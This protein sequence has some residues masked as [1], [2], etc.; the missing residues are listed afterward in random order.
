MSR[1][2]DVPFVSFRVLEDELRGELEACFT[3][4]LNNSWYIQ[5]AECDAFEKAFA[6]YVGVR[7]CVGCGNGLDALVLA[8]R[9]LGIGPGDEVIVPSNTFIATVLAVSQ[10]GAT[11]VLVEPNLSTYNLDASKVGAAITP[12]TAAIMPVHL[13]G[14]ACN[15]DPIIELAREHGLA[16]VEDCAQAH[17]ATYKGQGVGTFGV[18][19]GFS[20]Y[21]GKNLGAMGDAGAVVTND[22]DFARKVVAIGNYGSD[23]KY[24]HIY[25]GV[26]SRLDELQAAILH[27]KLATLERTN[28]FRRTVASRYLEG[29][30]NPLVVLPV[31]E[32]WA[33]PVW[34]IFAVRCEQRDELQ[35]HL[36]ERGIHTNIHYPTPIHLQGA[37]EDLP[38]GEGDLPI[39]EQISRTQLSIPMYYGMSDEQVA[40]VVESIN[41]F[42]GSAHSKQG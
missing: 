14:Q 7:H 24:H 19:S 2:M 32:D 39:A 20:F 17:G 36:E 34:H 13:Y 22:E 42:D 10:V 1:F 3:R 6:S 33:L 15:M 9:A 31:V 12:R 37:Y 5:G 41:G 18:A 23:R 25:Q 35:R 11:P 16:V 29:I 21:P 26:N 38:Y 30:T 8:L 40:W 4:V 28:E 27:A